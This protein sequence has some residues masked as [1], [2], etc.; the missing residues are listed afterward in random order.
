MERKR[1]LSVG[2]CGVDHSAI[3]W[4][5]RQSFGAQVTSASDAGEALAHLAKEKYDLILVNRILDG[6][7]SPGL[8]VIKK[9]KATPACAATPVMLV[10]NHESAQQEAVAL[11]A[12]PGFGKAALTDDAAME[13]VRPYLETT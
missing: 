3:T 9:I 1:V 2:Q 12:V 4:T 8:E 7:H 10:S 11:G 6:D 13:R 5:F